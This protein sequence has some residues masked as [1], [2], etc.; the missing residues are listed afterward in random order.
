MEN[1]NELELD[2]TIISLSGLINLKHL[3]SFGYQLSEASLVGLYR[4][5]SLVLESYD[6]KDFEM[7]WFNHLRNLNRL[8]LLCPGKVGFNFRELASLESFQSS[9]EF[10]ELRTVIWFEETKEI[11]SLNSCD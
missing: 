1:P 2:E 8:N 11:N 7:N 6:F 5:E 9:Y 4:L 10:Q 3:S